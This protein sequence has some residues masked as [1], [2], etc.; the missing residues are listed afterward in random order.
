MSEKRNRTL[1]SLVFQSHEMDSFFCWTSEFLWYSLHMTKMPGVIIIC[2]F[3][4]YCH[5]CFLLVKVTNKK[6]NINEEKIS[7]NILE[8]P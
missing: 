7:N 1:Y 4:I 6:I 2:S 5:L 3:F 8:Y